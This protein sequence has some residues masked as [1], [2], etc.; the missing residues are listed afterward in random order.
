M[1]NN[2]T[3]PRFLTAYGA[4]KQN[5]TPTGKRLELTY[6]YKVNKK[7]QKELVINGETDV[8]EKI[9]SYLEDT[10]IETVLARAAAGDG[11]VFRPD[12]MYG[13][14]TS[15]P[16][17][18]LEA[19]QMMQDLQNLWGNI[20]NE[21]KKEYGFSV[22]N[23]VAEAGSEKWLESMGYKQKNQEPKITETKT[24]SKGEKT[25]ES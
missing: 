5:N 16:K 20:P 19:Q 18:L 23:F 3:L 7:G 9:Q 8:Y 15:A 12:G 4:R 2:S 21:I 17:N 1:S 14:F 6:G 22:E 10:K 25:D 13:D 24:E 11:T